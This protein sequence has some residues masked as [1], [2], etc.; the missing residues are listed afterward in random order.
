MLFLTTLMGLRIREVVAVRVWRMDQGKCPSNK[1]E[2]RYQCCDNYCSAVI[3]FG[4]PMSD[5]KKSCFLLCT[6]PI[7]VQ[8]WIP[9]VVGSKSPITMTGRTDR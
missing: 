1:L 3:P 5:L 7:C 9:T 6:N 8:T 4:F 2:D